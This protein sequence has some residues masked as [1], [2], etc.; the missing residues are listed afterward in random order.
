MKM[1]VAIFA[2]CAGTM[3]CGGLMSLATPAAAAARAPQRAPIWFWLAGKKV[4]NPDRA[5]PN[6]LKVIR[7]QHTE[8]MWQGLKTKD[9]TDKGAR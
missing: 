9:K 7:G 3:L 5:N 4:P 1:R 6:K 2:V 8:F